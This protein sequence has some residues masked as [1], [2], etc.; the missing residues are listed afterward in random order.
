[1]VFW[2]RN[3]KVVQGINENRQAV[4]LYEKDLPDS[5]SATTD[6]ELAVRGVC[7]AV[8]AVPSVAVGKVSGFFA[9]LLPSDCLLV[10]ATKG[11]DPLTQK[12]PVEVWQDA[13]PALEKRLA[14][15]SGPNFAVEIAEAARRH[16]RS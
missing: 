12:R 16:C 4:N 15:I 11:F 8:S 2:D 6:G 3:P 13:E 10:S 5:V 14:A 7:L 9:P 1:M